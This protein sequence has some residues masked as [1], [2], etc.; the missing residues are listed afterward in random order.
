MSAQRVARRRRAAKAS[1]GARAGTKETSAR[2]G[3]KASSEPRVGS[4]SGPQPQRQ[5]L[6][7]L[8]S[9]PAAG[10][11][12]LAVWASFPPY[13]LWWLAPIGL[14]GLLTVVRGRRAWQ[15]ALIGAVFGAAMF[16]PL[17]H[18][19]AV[20]MGNS[21]GWAALTVLESLYLAGLGAAWALVSRL[22]W[23]ASGRQGPV[24]R[25]AAFAVLW[26][27]VEELRSSWPWGGFPFGRLAFAMADSPML[28]VAAYL[29][30]IG[31]SLMVALVGA[32]LAETCHQLRSARLVE[33]LTATVVAGLLVLAPIALPMASRAENGTIRVAAVQGN[34]AKDVD[35]AF[36]RAMEV[37][38]NHA[39]ATQALAGSETTGGLDMVI[40]PENAAD[41][42]PR[43]YPQ[44]AAVVERAAQAVGVPVLVGAVPHEGQ[45]RY[46]DIVIWNAGQGAGEY[47]RKHRPVPFAEYVPWRSWLRTVTD[48]VD[49]IGIDMLP[50][51]GPQTLTVHAAARDEDVVLAMGICFEV[52]YDST[53][54]EG[55]E[56]GGQVIVIPTTNASFRDSSEA[57]QQLAQGRVQAV[58]H[59]RAVVQVST[60]GITAIINPRGVVEQRTDPFTQASLVANVPLRETM[61]VA[62]RLGGAPGLV[63]SLAAAG[64]TAAGMVYAGR[65]A[66]GRLRSRRS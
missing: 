57:A 24:V 53:L 22:P 31:L 65:Q 7:P 64:L 30:S 11:C 60:V 38:G 41:L 39:D 28:P 26:C 51:T 3:T 13:D 48:Q 5:P 14:A 44:S 35:N 27:G 61:T 18:F 32:S 1:S 17:L 45:V 43:D 2:V 54:R 36:A 20:A 49:R 4:G 42:D 52:A 6:D 8:H 10:V 56:Q 50:G 40:W 12:G 47:Y 15:G 33:S 58:V 23:C 19:A 37:T 63:L 55:V 21:V 66:L 46:N 16:A 25:V 59:G 29:G 62:D 34:V 9:L